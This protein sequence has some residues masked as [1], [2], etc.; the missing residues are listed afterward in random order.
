M[1]VK[2]VLLLYV[3][4]NVLCVVC[5]CWLCV[6]GCLFSFAV[7]GWSVHVVHCCQLLLFSVYCVLLVAGCWWFWCALCVVVYLLS[8]VVWDVCH[9][10]RWPCCCVLFVVCCVRFGAC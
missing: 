10:A 8:L 2:C 5:W 4:N 7:V 6:N 9:V 1:F 3:V